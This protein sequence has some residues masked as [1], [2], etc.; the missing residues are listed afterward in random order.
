MT[1]PS[2]SVRRSH[3]PTASRRRAGGKLTRSALRRAD[4]SSG[5]VSTG[6]SSGGSVEELRSVSNQLGR[7]A[8]PDIQGNKQER[9]CCSRWTYC[10]E[11][12]PVSG[13]DQAAEQSGITGH[14]GK[15]GRRTLLIKA[16]GGK[17]HL[18]STPDPALI[19]N[20]SLRR[21]FNACNNIGHGPP[22]TNVLS[23]CRHQEI[24]QMKLSTTRAIRR[25]RFERYRLKKVLRH[26]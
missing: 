12:S 3:R 17:T 14:V 20:G 4:N 19:S 22:E 1:R 8:L 10:L 25:H 23:P 9:I 15:V 2:C 18:V 7:G 5:L 11:H 16:C 26:R 6:G 21:K 13:S 24:A